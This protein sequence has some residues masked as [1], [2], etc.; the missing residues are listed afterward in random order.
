M[1]RNHFCRKKKAAYNLLVRKKKVTMVFHTFNFFFFL[2]EMQNYYCCCSVRVH[3]QR[4][5]SDSLRIHG[6]QHTRLPC[7]LPSHR[8]CSNSSP[9]SQWCHPNISSSVIPFSSCPQSFP[10]SGSF[11]VSQLFAS[12]GQCIGASVQFSHSVVSD[13]SRPYYSNAWLWCH[14]SIG[15]ILYKCWWW[16]H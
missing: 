16:F 14:G 5:M 4:I 12:G 1:I 8:V 9:L 15:H 10:A 6:L 11:P 3:V 13:S 7:P 2:E